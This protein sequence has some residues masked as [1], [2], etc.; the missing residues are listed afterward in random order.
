MVNWNSFNKTYLIVTLNIN[1]R[2]G[3]TLDSLPKETLV[4][5]FTQMVRIREFE[6]AIVES[7]R[8]GKVATPGLLHLCSGQEAT[9]VGT[10]MNLRKDDYITST[11]RGHG[12]CLA[13]GGD[14]N[15]MMAEIWGKKTGYCKGKGG[16]M[17]IAVPEI[18]I[19][20]CS[21]I[22]GAGIPISAGVG[23]SIQHRG[24]DQ[25][26]VAFFGDGA[27]NTGGFH[28]GISL[29]AAWNLPIVYL[30]ENNL[31]AISVCAGDVLKVEDIAERGPG[32]GIP[33]VVVDGMNVVD[34]YNAVTPAVERARNGGGPTLIECKT[35]R[36]LG[37]YLGDPNLGVGH[38]RSESEMEHWKER[39]PIIAFRGRLETQGILGV[40]ELD[41]IESGA[42]AE[43]EA[44][45]KFADDSPFPSPEV[46]FED[47]FV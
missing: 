33:S 26:C 21:G 35:Y 15:K 4:E 1:R 36:Y 41:T 39:D 30:C 13:K 12:H 27:V 19:V 37:H 43:A 17:H 32:Y 7:Y 28:E 45:V 44:A 5:M 25:V 9:A 18:G 14:M 20:G 6:E 10:C 2:T 29:A 16:S 31:Y 22:V 40:K 46:A 47:L 11:H 3:M 34:V 8:A 24:T 23:L 42:K 38:Y